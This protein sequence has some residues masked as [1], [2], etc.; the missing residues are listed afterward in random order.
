MRVGFDMDGV[1]Y[2]FRQAHSDFEVGR[3]N[4]HCSIERAF[5]CWDYFEGWG[6]TLDDWL[7]SYAEGVDAGQILRHGEPL[8][9]AVMAFRELRAQGH[10]IH[11][12]TDRSIGSD[13]QGATR[14]WLEDHGF[15][16]DTLT[17]SRDKSAVPTDIYIDDRL[18][19]ADALNHQTSTLC[20]LINRPWNQQPNDHRPR[21]DTLDEFVAAVAQLGSVMINR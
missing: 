16:Y 7:K 2:D 20:Y 14:A 1:I 11:I 9:G 8:P 19:N 3:G 18:E 12:I 4:A 10:S 13:P 5:D 15:V 6:F 17:F 21:V